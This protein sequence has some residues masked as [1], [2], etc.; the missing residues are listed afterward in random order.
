MTATLLSF[1][2]RAPGWSNEEQA[3]LVRVERLIAGAGIAVETEMGETDEGDPWCVFCLADTGEVVVHLARIDGRYSLVSR[4]ISTP[5]EGVSLSHCAERFLDEAVALAPAPRNAQAQGGFYI[6]PSAML[7]GVMM[8]I[9]L[10]AV[11]Q[12]GG[13]ARASVLG[14]EGTGVAP[15]PEEG[16][17]AAALAALLE[18]D[19]LDLDMPTAEEIAAALAA[20]E[21][22]A[23]EARGTSGAEGTAEAAEM[24]AKLRQISQNVTSFLQDAMRAERNGD[25]GPQGQNWA[26]L[27]SAAMIVALAIVQDEGLRKALG[28]LGEG[29]LVGAPGTD[30]LVLLETAAGALPTDAQGTG[31]R[32]ET[33]GNDQALSV[34]TAETHDFLGLGAGFWSGL[35]AALAGKNSLDLEADPS[36]G[37]SSAG[38]WTGVLGSLWASLSAGISTTFGTAF[39]TAFASTVGIAG[40]TTI[41]TGLG[42]A[43]MPEDSLS[44]T[45]AGAIPALDETLATPDDS[46]PAERAG[47]SALREETARRAESAEDTPFTLS[48]HQD[49]WQ[50]GLD[51]GGPAFAIQDLMSELAGLARFDGVLTLMRESVAELSGE[52]SGALDTLGDATLGNTTLGNTTLGSTALGNGMTVTASANASLT[53]I[54]DQ[55]RDTTPI[56]LQPVFQPPALG[57]GPALPNGALDGAGV[58]SAGGSIAGP[59]ARDSLVFAPFSNL[60]AAPMATERGLATEDRT[61]LLLGSVDF[62]PIDGALV[63][64]HYTLDREPFFD[65]LRATDNSSHSRLIDGNVVLVDAR[66]EDGFIQAPRSAP[67]VLDPLVSVSLTYVDESSAVLILAESDLDAWLS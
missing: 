26:L 27:H 59:I 53:L 23:A 58:S 24:A 55:T 20:A 2:R 56:A 28:G 25:A 8:T 48:P 43:G 47:Q 12:E 50:D 61:G 22:D 42:T 13:Q 52:V 9:M 65:L 35:Q 64:R 33:G 7:A 66:L 15:D 18:G 1:A 62:G 54:A 14:E 34:A 37:G 60:L 11:L 67:D 4:F 21:V 5:L 45:L 41:G 16:L 44:G 30:G 49:S 19:T 63:T 40:S 31:D 32:A 29:S 3:L 36:A 10:Y 39:G 46:A 57:S 51:S 38:T 17:D 6:H